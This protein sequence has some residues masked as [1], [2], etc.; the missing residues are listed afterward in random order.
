VCMN[1]CFSEEVAAPRGTERYLGSF[2]HHTVLSLPC[3]MGL[4]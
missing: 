2:L 3:F 4:L 1:S